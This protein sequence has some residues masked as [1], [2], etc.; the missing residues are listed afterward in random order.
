MERAVREVGGYLHHSLQIDN[1][2]TK[3]AIRAL[4]RALS[5]ATELDEIDE[6]LRE[7]RKKRRERLCGCCG[8]GEG[9]KKDDKKD[10]EKSASIAQGGGGFVRVNEQ[11]QPVCR[12]LPEDAEKAVN[13]TDPVLFE[14]KK[15]E[16]KK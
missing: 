3:S 12:L 5:K 4:G 8:K 11:G 16:E 1:L 10:K 15:E 9:E 13:G 14:P 6:K 2:R 7:Y